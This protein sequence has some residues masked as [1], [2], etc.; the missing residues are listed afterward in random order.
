[1]CVCSH[2]IYTKG[3]RNQLCL[4]IYP[5]W[6]QNRSVLT[7]TVKHERDTCMLHKVFILSSF[8]DFI[9]AQWPLPQEAQHVITFQLK[10]TSPLNILD[11]Y[12]LY[13]SCDDNSK[14]QVQNESK[15]VQEIIA[16][17]IGT[18]NKSFKEWGHST[19]DSFWWLIQALT[20]YIHV[21][22]SG[23][24][25]YISEHKLTLNMWLSP[26]IWVRFI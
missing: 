12:L 14:A 16:N 8:M 26:L 23:D 25:Q 24:L 13:H 6:T 5:F 2:A 15:P 10:S 17:A 3:N 11:S 18:N 9:A 4:F 7:V 19:V 22:H 21:I 1:M 20:H